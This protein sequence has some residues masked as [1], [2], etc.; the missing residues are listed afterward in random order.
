M[1]LDWECEALRSCLNWNNIE[2][3]GF[4]CADTIPIIYLGEVGHAKQKP[5]ISSFGNVE[6]GMA[7]TYFST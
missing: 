7:T 3:F 4:Q 6:P 1:E 2:G 5:Y